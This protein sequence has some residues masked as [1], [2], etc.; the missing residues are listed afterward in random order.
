M[1]IAHLRPSF[2]G[3]HESQRNGLYLLSRRQ[4]QQ[5][6]GALWFLDGL[7]Q[8]QPSMFT[9]YL[10]SGIMQP[11]A[12]GQPGLVS[13]TIQPMI[14]LTSRLLI[15]VNLTIIL[16][17]VTIGICLLTGRFVRPAILG[18]VAWALMVWY[19][20]EGMG[21]L[22]TGNASALTG[23][24]GAVLLYAL[25]GLA[26]YPAD[27]SGG[28]DL[29][30]QRYLRWILVG[31]WAFTAMLQLQPVWWRPQQIAQVIAANES[32]GTLNGVLLNRSLQWLSALVGNWE[33]P[34]NIGLITLA[35][36]LA[37]GLAVVRPDKVR[38]FL[39]GS[40]VLSL[41]LWWATEG[42][43]LLFSGAATDVN[44]GPLLVAL[45][46]TC[47]PATSAVK[48]ATGIDTSSQAPDLAAKWVRRGWL[49]GTEAVMASVDQGP[50]LA[51]A[52]ST[53]RFEREEASR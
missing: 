21:M 10:I 34:L 9:R 18:S 28:A 15:P 35:L 43:G 24:P 32:P 25:L 17:Q 45:A 47:W 50:A 1:L 16:V 44:S 39:V 40:I 53:Q 48:A 12:Q 20:G 42:L 19:G 41:L 8:L 38:P 22:L 2:L 33:L 11:A 26:A 23:A 27:V 52:Q 13:A 37:I 6:L 4:L 31:F 29:L 49:G 14:A 7:L 51:V 5:V 30:P 36:G 3:A 46:L